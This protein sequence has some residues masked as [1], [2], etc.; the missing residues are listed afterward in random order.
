MSDLAGNAMTTTV[1][2]AC[3]LSALL[4]MKDQL[5]AHTPKVQKMVKE[6]AAR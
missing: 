4:L 5:V 6:A 2:G 3:M 1:V